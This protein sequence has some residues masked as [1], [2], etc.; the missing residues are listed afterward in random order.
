M[1]YLKSF[2]NIS[3]RKFK[4]GDTIIC[5][6]DDII[7]EDVFDENVDIKEGEKYIIYKIL[8]TPDWNNG[9]KVQNYK[10]GN[11]LYGYWPSENFVYPE[12]YETYV[13]TQKYN[14]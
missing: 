5:V 4:K 13:N 7:D 8:N 11:I 6:K 3:E 9:L 2:E 1:K 14:I 12:D 10:N